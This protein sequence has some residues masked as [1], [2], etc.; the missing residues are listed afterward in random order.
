MTDLSRPLRLYQPRRFEFGAG[1]AAQVG[2]WAT[3]QGF[4]RIMVVTSPSML[5]TCP[6]E[7]PSL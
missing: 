1:T 4:K 6:P 3:A 5:L 7:T 2:D